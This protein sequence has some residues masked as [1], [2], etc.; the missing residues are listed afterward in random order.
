[1]TIPVSSG[2]AC[3]A[4][5]FLFAAFFVALT[6]PAF[7]QTASTPLRHPKAYAAPER[8][9]WIQPPAREAPVVLPAPDSPAASPMSAPSPA[10]EGP[11]PS[12]VPGVTIVV[13]NNSAESLE[14]YIN[15]SFRGLLSPRMANAY[16]GVA[17]GLVRLYARSTGRGSGFEHT[18]QLDPGA[19]VTWRL[20]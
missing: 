20:P 19:I 7:A 11:P 12:P 2:L 9:L 3:S 18:W 13:L 14:V 15:G 1:M 10:L 5:G 16:A 8:P 17:P 4:V 6:E